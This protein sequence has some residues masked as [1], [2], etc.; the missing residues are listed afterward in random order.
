MKNVDEGASGLDGWSAMGLLHRLIFNTQYVLQE[1][2]SE[3][4][5]LRGPS[6]K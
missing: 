5:G 3:L 2:G 6:L 4:S 1:L